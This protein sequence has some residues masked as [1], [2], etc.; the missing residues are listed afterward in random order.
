MSLV[1]PE[2][3]RKLQAALHTKAKEAPNYRFYALYDKV[4]RR[5]VL[6]YAYERCRQNAGAPG[7][8]GQTFDDIE[9]S[10]R[11][12]WL[13]ALMQISS[14]SN[15]PSQPDSSGV[16][17]QAGRQATSAWDRHDSGPRGADGVGGS[18][19]GNLRG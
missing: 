14:G 6:T 2:T 7:V 5:D 16:H 19:G 12:R 4:C 9:A 11:D 3:V 10:G 8:D 13:D 1:P 15:V 17:P 18:L